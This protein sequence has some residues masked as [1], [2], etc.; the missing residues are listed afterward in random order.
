MYSFPADTSE[1]KTKLDH[2]QE[3]LLTTLELVPYTCLLSVHPPKGGSW[4]MERLDNEATQI[5]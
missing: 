2:D 1:G 5:P 3:A 4:C